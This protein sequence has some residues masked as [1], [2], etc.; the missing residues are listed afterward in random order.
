MK[1]YG[2]F[3]NGIQ[4][5][6]RI[7]YQKKEFFI[8]NFNSKEKAALTFN[9]CSTF[10]YGK[11]TKLNNVPMTDDLNEFISNWKIPDRIKMLKQ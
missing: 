5:G 2:T 6:A 10:L 4:V 8:G 11:N 1:Y 7:V 3:P 9:K